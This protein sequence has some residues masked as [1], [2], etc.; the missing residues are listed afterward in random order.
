MCDNVAENIEIGSDLHT[1]ESRISADFP[2]RFLP[3]EWTEWMNGHFDAFWCVSEHEPRT[4][5][6]T[7]QGIERN[8]NRNMVDTVQ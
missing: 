6:C 5:K 4:I 2:R 3:S 7:K 8:N 1:E